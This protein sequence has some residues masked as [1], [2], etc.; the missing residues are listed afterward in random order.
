MSDYNCTY[1]SVETVDSDSVEAACGDSA[2][3]YIGWPYF[4]FSWCLSVAGAGL[5]VLS[6]GKQPRDC[7]NSRTA[8]RVLL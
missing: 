4:L 8:N 3:D 7:G 2:G 5:A 1:P 6:F